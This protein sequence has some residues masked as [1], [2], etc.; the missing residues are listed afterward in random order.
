MKDVG[1]PHTLTHTLLQV[2]DEQGEREKNQEE[3][4]RSGALLQIQPFVP[5][6]NWL[7]SRFWNRDMTSGAFVPGVELGQNV[8]DAKIFFCTSRDSIPRL[9][10]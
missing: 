10:A 6:P 7:L 3:H 2:E 5:V 1:F 8:P 9:I 4:T